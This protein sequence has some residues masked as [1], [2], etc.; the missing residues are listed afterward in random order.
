MDQSEMVRVIDMASLPASKDWIT[1]PF[2]PLY[3][4]CHLGLPKGHMVVYLD[5]LPG[6]VS[7]L[8]I[9]GMGFL[10]QFQRRIPFTLCPLKKAVPLDRC[11]LSVAP[12]LGH[13]VSPG[14]ACG[15]FFAPARY[16]VRNK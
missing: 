8:G 13:C 3:L 15:K 6:I 1:R 2:A 14:R 4:R 7:Q 10:T 5:I 12:V 11:V 9:A 16:P